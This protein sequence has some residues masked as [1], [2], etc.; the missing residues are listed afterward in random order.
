MGSFVDLPG[1][2]QKLVPFCAATGRPSVD[3][4]LTICMLIIGYGL[5]I[6]SESRLRDEIQ[7]NSIDRCPADSYSTAGRRSVPPP[8]GTVMAAS[9]TGAPLRYL[10]ETVLAHCIAEGLLGGEASPSMAA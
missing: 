3:P 8:P 1:L 4:E 6:R 7:L 5:G 2:R 10:S 9:G